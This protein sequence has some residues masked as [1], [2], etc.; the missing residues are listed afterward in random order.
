MKL[1]WKFYHGTTIQNLGDIYKDGVIK[2]NGSCITNTF[3]YAKCYALR[4]DKFGAVIILNEE[5]N[6]SIKDLLIFYF[7]RF[8][9]RHIFCND[10]FFYWYCDNFNTFGFFDNSV[11]LMIME[12]VSINNIIDIKIVKK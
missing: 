7:N 9:A 3:N 2:N 8:F 11:E 12:N 6:L 5:V 1:K 4:N 10:Y